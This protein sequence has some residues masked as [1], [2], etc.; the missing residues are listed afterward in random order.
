MAEPFTELLADLVQH[1]DGAV[2]A[3]FIDSNGEAVKCLSSSGDDDFVKL[4]GAYQ[5]I[6]LQTTR[7][8]VS[9]LDSGKVDYFFS[10]YEHASF[11]VKA[12]AHDYFLLLVLSP[13]ANVG[14]GVHNIRRSAEAFNQEI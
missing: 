11:L 7:G 3:A 6:A 14:K 4:V 13:D 12:L 8:I 2:G 10:A 9:Q 1:V 5:G